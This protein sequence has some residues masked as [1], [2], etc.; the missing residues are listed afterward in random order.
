MINQPPLS[1]SL[2][3]NI[4]NAEETERLGALL[5]R[6]IPKAAVIFL[7]GELGAGKTT[8]VRGFLR[9]LGHRGP[10]KSPTFTLIEP[11]EIG[12]RPIYHLDLYR[13]GAPEELDSLGARD[14][15]GTDSTCLVEWP[16][17][18]AGQL[19]QPDIAIHIEHLGAGRKS[20]LEAHTVDGRRILGEIQ[21][22]WDPSSTHSDNDT[23]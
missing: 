15:F 13:M 1:G 5:A 14:L 7:Y 22:R 3:R 8:L 6:A 12:D 19:G 23:R 11:Y 17:R 18:A 9:A 20:T 10:V 4:P 2:T 16:E 21:V